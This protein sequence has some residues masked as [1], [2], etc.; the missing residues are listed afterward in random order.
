[1][2]KQ[3]QSKEFRNKSIIKSCLYLKKD[4]IQNIL[5]ILRKTKIVFTY[6]YEIY[7][8]LIIVLRINQHQLVLI[9]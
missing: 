3:K 8:Y 2:L 7:Q 5:D 9:D 4:G 6:H 1:M